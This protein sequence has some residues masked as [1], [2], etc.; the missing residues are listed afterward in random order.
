[1]K[2]NEFKISLAIRPKV[3]VIYSYMKE[4]NLTIKKMAEIIGV[5]EVWLGMVVNFKLIPKREDGVATKKLLAFFDVE[6]S[7]I[8]PSASLKMIAGDHTI[9]KTIP[10][11]NLISWSREQFDELPSIEYDPQKESLS[12]DVSEAMKALPNDRYREILKMYY[13]LDG[14]KPLTQREIG[15]IYDITDSRVSEI[16][17]RCL[18]KLRLPTPRKILK[19]YV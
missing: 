1:M 4:N 10:K 2:E 18:R 6:F 11:E 7:D 14:N 9:T 19:K 3:G 8:F 16:I 13:G 17:R 12:E 5:G 15:E